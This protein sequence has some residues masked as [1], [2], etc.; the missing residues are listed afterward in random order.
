MQLDICPF[1]EDQQNKRGINHFQI[2]ENVEFLPF[3]LR[4]VLEILIKFAWNRMSALI[5]KGQNYK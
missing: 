2:Q 5:I 3:M 1:Q 4:Y